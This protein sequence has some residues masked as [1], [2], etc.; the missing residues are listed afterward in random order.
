MIYNIFFFF[1]Q[2]TAYEIVSG[3]W[4]SDVCSSDLQH[5]LGQTLNTTHAATA[6][7]TASRLASRTRGGTEHPGASSNPRPPVSRIARWASVLIFDAGPKTSVER[8]LSPPIT[9]RPAISRPSASD[10]L[11]WLWIDQL[12]AC[13]AKLRASAKLRFEPHRWTTLN[14]V[15]AGMAPSTASS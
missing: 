5:D 4:S 12:T 3:D 1:K 7:I 9:A 2:K 8:W 6:N 11:P 13:E 14:H 15:P 10:G